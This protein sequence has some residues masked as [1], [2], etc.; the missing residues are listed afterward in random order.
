MWN[1]TEAEIAVNR[2]FFPY[3]PSFVICPIKTHRPF[4]LYILLLYLFL[5]ILILHSYLSCLY[6]Q[7]Y[8]QYRVPTSL[9]NQGKCFLGVLHGNKKNVKGK[10]KKLWVIRENS[11]KLFCLVE[12]NIWFR[13]IFSCFWIHQRINVTYLFWFAL[14]YVHNFCVKEVPQKNMIFLSSLMFTKVQ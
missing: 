2:L 10:W 12:Y 7:I 14:T 9:E 1:S 11:G 13:H 4:N 6:L 8:Y 5:Y 3:G